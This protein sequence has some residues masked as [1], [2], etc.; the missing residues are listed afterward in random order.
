MFT[1]LYVQI[2]IIEKFDYDVFLNSK[3]LY[4]FAT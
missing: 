3:E 2:W 1:E 4:R